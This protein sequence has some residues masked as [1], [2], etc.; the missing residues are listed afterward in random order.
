LAR[1]YA[2]W[3]TPLGGG[4]GAARQICEMIMFAQGHYNDAMQQYL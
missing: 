4:Q 1:H 2:H 3:T